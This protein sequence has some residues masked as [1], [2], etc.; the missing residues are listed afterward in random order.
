MSRCKYERIE[1]QLEIFMGYIEIREKLKS[2]N[3]FLVVKQDLK[4]IG[5]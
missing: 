2:K 1:V 3:A 5:I 4:E